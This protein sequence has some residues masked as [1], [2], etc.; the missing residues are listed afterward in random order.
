MRK[1]EDTHMRWIAWTLLMAV[2]AAVV[3]PVHA[4]AVA[5]GSPTLTVGFTPNYRAIAQHAGPAVVAVVV[6]GLREPMSSAGAP[7]AERSPLPYDS[8]GRFPGQG[9]GFIISPDGLVLTSAHVI[10]G[11]RRVTV[12]LSDRR[13]FRARVVGSDPVT[14]VAVLRVEAGHLPFLRVG[15]VDQLLPGDAV[16]AIGAPFGLEQSVSHGIVS[17]KGRALPGMSAVPHIQTDAP[18]NP[19]HS[20]GPLLDASGAVVGMHAQIFS[21]SGGYQGLSFA[22]PIDVALKVKDHLVAHGRMPHGYLGVTIQSLNP[23]LASAFGLAGSQGALV[24]GVDAGSAAESAGLRAGDVITHVN[25]SPV[26]RAA[27]LFAHLG[28]A[29]PGDQVRLSLWRARQSR[30]LVVRLGEA[31]EADEPLAAEDSARPGTRELG[32]RL[33]SLTAQERALLGTEGGVWV[34]GVGALSAQAGLR[35]GDV[36]LSINLKPVTSVESVRKLLNEATAQVA[37]LIDRDGLRMFVAMPL[38]GS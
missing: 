33:R 18:I 38:D 28:A 12:R 23:T 10:A 30:D 37:L 35:A 7:D 3:P 27:E 5:E 24:G 4:Q 1:Y 13:E 22:V 34:D 8:Q 26:G 36:L 9:S 19:G 20:G 25:G 16:L 29:V 15:Q 21:S 17:A 32:W 2:A 14:D 31:M 11:A 6:E